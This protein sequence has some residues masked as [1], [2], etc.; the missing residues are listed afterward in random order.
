MD[1]R[2]RGFTLIELLVVIA[3]I[4]LL[5]GILLPSLGAARESGRRT[6][7]LNAQ[8]MVAMASNLYANQHPRG[9]FLPSKTPGS[10][11]LAYLTDFL[12]TPEAAVCPSTS[13]T[14]DASLR[15]LP[16]GK[17]VGPGVEEVYFDKNPHGRDVPF[18]LRG[19]AIE[20]S[21]DGVY[22]QLSGS[23]NLNDRGHSFE[24]WAWFGYKTT[25]GL[26]KWPDGSFRPRYHT[27]PTL[28]QAIR[29]YNRDRGV[30]ADDPGAIEVE[31]LTGNPDDFDANF[32]DLDRYLKRLDNTEFPAWTLLSLDGDEDHSRSIREQYGRD[33]SG[34]WVVLGNWPD[35]Q[36]NNHG[37]DGLN[38]SFAD[39]H[40]R[41]VN[42]GSD[43]L[44]TYVRSR[45]VGVS[46]I[47]SGRAV[48]GI[49][50]AY[51]NEIER[52]T[53]RLGRNNGVRF[54]IK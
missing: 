18:D 41:F 27:P 24:F 32:G 44:K 9:A 30:N 35:E 17:V 28:Q 13:N 25:F 50:D 38:I 7:C 11:N 21:L 23:A 43:L 6:V 45:H 22:D 31:D 29:D 15:W 5:I 51:E 37:D 53:I 8:R 48:T 14:V 33:S 42:K 12:E 26:T 1:A 4:A 40:A 46:G 19:N 39:G 52:E 54:I 47:D 3:I 49:Y 20:A 34:N 16:D 10:D 36:T 2:R